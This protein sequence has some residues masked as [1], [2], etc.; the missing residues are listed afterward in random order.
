MHRGTPVGVEYMEGERVSVGFD[1]DGHQ[2]VVHDRWRD[3]LGNLY[4]P[5]K[6]WKGWT[7]LKLPVP[8]KPSLGGRF[9]EPLPLPADRFGEKEKMGH[10]EG[11]VDNYGATMGAVDMLWA[12]WLTDR[13]R[14]VSSLASQSRAEDPLE[15]FHGTPRIEVGG[16][17]LG[18]SSLLS[19][20]E[21]DMFSYNFG[22]VG[23]WKRN[24][25]SFA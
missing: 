1:M 18:H 7:F 21:S 14:V 19:S 5:K 20:D 15:V 10:G 17:C 11:L 8:L 25:A 12:L 3:P 22:F 4:N 13:G 23:L 6:S 24:M 9:V 2:T 16:V